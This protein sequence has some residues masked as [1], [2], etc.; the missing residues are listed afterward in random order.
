MKKSSPG[1]GT[2]PMAMIYQGSLYP[3]SKIKKTKKKKREK[4][5]TFDLGE[6]L[7][8]GFDRTEDIPGLLFRYYQDTVS[9]CSNRKKRHYHFGMKNE[10]K[11]E[12]MRI[13]RKQSIF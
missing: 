7:N 3:R 2:R 11:K 8:K 4:E 1:H 12:K 13:R 5:I 9:F 10:K 6:G